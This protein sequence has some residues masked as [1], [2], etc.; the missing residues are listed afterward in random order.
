MDT[1]C[2]TEM[3][4]INDQFSTEQCHRLSTTINHL[5]KRQKEALYLRYYEKMSYE[6]IMQVMDLSYKSVRNLVSIAIQTLRK[7]LQKH[8]FIY[9]I[10]LYIAH[11]F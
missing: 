5:P 4:L 3:E 1:A 11:I 6:E 2:S 8:D 10:L 7:V 9:G